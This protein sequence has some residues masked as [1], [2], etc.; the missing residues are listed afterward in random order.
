VSITSSQTLSAVAIDPAG[1]PSAIARFEY[2]IAPGPAAGPSAAAMI[3]VLPIAPGQRVQGARAAALPAVH[4]L[5]VAVLHGHGLRLTMRLG[6]RAGVVRFQVLRARNGRRTGG[7]LV[8]V[9]RVPAAG[10]RYVVTLRG[11]ALRGL[12]PG[13]YV[14]EARAGTSRDALGASSRRTFVIG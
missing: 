9:Y 4:G 11:H 6:S 8:T 12:R 7:A 1:N 2:R 13:R 3:P 10:G 5:A 14:L